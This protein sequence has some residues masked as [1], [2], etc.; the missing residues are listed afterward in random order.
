[1]IRVVASGLRDFFF[2]P[3]LF[4]V[5]GTLAVLYALAMAHR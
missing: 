2:S 5:A 1:M 4:V 3:M